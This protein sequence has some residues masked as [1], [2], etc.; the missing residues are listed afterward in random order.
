[1]DNDVNN[2]A[3]TLL[4]ANYIYGFILLLIL[5]ALKYN[6]KNNALQTIA[7]VGKKV[8]RRPGSVWL[9]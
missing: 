7:Q 1:V 9:L 8:H 4:S 6:L 2:T 5:S 3:T